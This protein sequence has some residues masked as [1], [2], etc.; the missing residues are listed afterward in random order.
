MRPC[1][2]LSLCMVNNSHQIF[3]FSLKMRRREIS[4]QRGLVCLGAKSLPRVAFA[5]K[6]VLTRE[7]VGSFRISNNNV[8]NS[9]GIIA[10]LIPWNAT[11]IAIHGKPLLSRVGPLAPI[12]ML[13]LA[14]IASVH[15]P[16]VH[17]PADNELCTED[18]RQGFPMFDGSGVGREAKSMRSDC[19]LLCWQY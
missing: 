18:H 11:A 8:A 1:L 7:N 16:L 9:S 4:F 17:S 10:D 6:I 19:P 5:W 12:S 14:S 15:A 13:H 3:D 2:A